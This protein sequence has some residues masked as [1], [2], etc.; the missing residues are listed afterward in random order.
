MNGGEGCDDGNDNPA[1]G[2]LPDCSVPESC[3]DI[4]RTSPGSPSGAYILDLDGVGPG[5]PTYEHCEMELDD[6]G[7]T[8]ALVTADDGNNTW[9]WN[10]REL[11]TFDSTRIGDLDELDRDFKSASQQQTSFKDLLFV[12]HPSLEW[13]AYE[14]V[15]NW[16]S[17]F[18]S[19]IADQP[20]PVCTSDAGFE[21][22]GGTLLTNGTSLCDTRLYIH[23]GDRDGGSASV[24]E[25]LDI[26]TPPGSGTNTY[27]FGPA[28]NVD[29]NQ[30]C[31][32]DDPDESGL[33]PLAATCGETC[34]W[35][36]LEREGRGF[37]RAL[38]VPTDGTQLRVYVR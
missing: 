25:C 10:N 17:S 16:S 11:M 32:F 5:R 22:T 28:W 31:P 34:D 15:G 12:H 19:F 6:G 14:D 21:M 9:T 26:T 20:A 33:G 24:A 7:W 2:C 37:A 3:R 29:H 27:A 36:D 13:A 8:L 38:G 23:L 4:A 18:G 30:G 35:G 1:D